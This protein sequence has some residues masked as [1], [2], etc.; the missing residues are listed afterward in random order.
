LLFAQFDPDYLVLSP[1]RFDN[2]HYEMEN[3]Q[4]RNWHMKIMKGVL[5]VALAAHASRS[6]G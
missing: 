1:V 3:W 6:Y 5:A 2:E 4:R